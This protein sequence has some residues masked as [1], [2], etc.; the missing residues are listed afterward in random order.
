MGL[1]Y[2][3]IRNCS[4]GLSL[5][6]LAGCGTAEV[7]APASTAG[8][9]TVL[10]T[11]VPTEVATNVPTAT[12]TVVAIAALEDTSADWV[13]MASVEGDLYIRGNPNAP[14]RLLDYSDFL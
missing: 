4:I 5:M 2:W 10:P 12:P 6:L 9:P 1:K 11:T 8:A 7:G 13:N 3:W 14:L